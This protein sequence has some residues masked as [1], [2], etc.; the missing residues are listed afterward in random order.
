MTLLPL[1]VSCSDVHHRQTAGEKLMLL[2]CRE[3]EEYEIASISNAHLL[4]MSVLIDRV[5]ELAGLEEQAIIVY[6]HHGGRS[7]QVAQWLRD[8]GFSRSQSM[9]GGIDCWAEE[10]EPG[11][12][13]Y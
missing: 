7:A 5:G 13:R 6:C 3:A 8:Q 10:I 12:A 9:D 2:D 1:E 4:P 11:M